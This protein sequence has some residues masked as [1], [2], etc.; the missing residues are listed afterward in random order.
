MLRKNQIEAL[1]ISNNNDFKSGVHFHATGTGKSWIG[2]QLILNYHNKYPNRNIIWIC[3][4]KSILIEQFNIN[5]L[6]EKGYYNIFT[7]F[8]VLNFSENKAKNWID[9]INSAKFWNKPLFVIINRAFLVSQEKYK[10]I[11]LPFS[12]LIHDECHSISNKT[13]QK[14][15]KWILKSTPNISCIGLSATP[16]ISIHPYKNILSKYSIYNSFCDN[17]IL[18]CKICWITS[19]SVLTYNNLFILFINLIKGLPYKKII[20]WCGMIDLCETLIK[21]I[22]KINY[23]SDFQ[24]FIDTSKSDTVNYYNKFKSIDEKAILFCACKHRE[25]SDIPNLDC[26]IFMDKVENRNPKTFVQCVG[27]VLR[28]D[29]LN[30][31]KYGLIIDVKA[32]NSMKLCNRMNEFLQLEPNIF[33]WKFTNI[34]ITQ[35]SKKYTINSMLL[36]KNNNQHS[37]QVNKF[38][39]IK[40]DNNLEKY[41]I[42]EIPEDDRYKI[43]YEKELSILKNKNLISYLLLAKDILDLSKNYP[44]VTRGSCG[45]SLI[46]YLLGISHVDP[47]QYNIHFE[48]FLNEYR[49]TLPD[50][51]F[52][53]PHNVRDEIFLKIEMKWPGKIARISNHIYYHPK[54]ALREAIRKNGY[55]K[56]IGKY[57][58]NKFIKSLP[59]IKQLKIQIDSKKL[60]NKFRCYSLHCG[61]IVFFPDGVPENLKLTEKKNNTLGQIIYNKKDISSCKKF[62]ID[63]LSS[64]ALSQIYTIYREPIQFE[65]DNY[66]QKIVDLL[67]SGD[68]IGLT[69]AESPLIRKAFIKIKPKNIEQIGICL[70][71]I[72][73]AAKEARLSEDNDFKDKFIFDDDGIEILSQ[74]LECEFD[75][76][77]KYRRGFSKKDKTILKEINDKLDLKLKKKYK[78]NYKKYKKNI[79]TKLN[80]LRK[81]SFCKSHSYSYGQLIWQLAYLKVYKPQK[82]WNATLLNCRSSYKKW[83]HYHEALQ[84]GIKYYNEYSKKNDIS[85]YS[86]NRKKKITLL[87]LNQQLKEYGYWDMEKHSDFYPNCYLIKNDN[88]FKIRGIIASSRMLSKHLSLFN[89]EKHDRLVLFIGIDTRQY[90]EIILELDKKEF[91]PKFI[92]IQC[93]ECELIDGECNIFISRKYKFF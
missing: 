41:F 7:Y 51:D 6:K 65:I 32:K 49:N 54:S 76:A 12:L 42:R 43:R 86:E 92:G 15:Y 36:V 14:F 52:D 89:K 24:L 57:E 33:P 48:R 88:K 47:I 75:L 37:K 22:K 29:K 69:L 84:F 21:I 20:I 80:N 5:I 13:T 53:F 8:Q 66:D 3:E 30:K 46:C 16:N 23:Y 70:A 19:Q 81:Y 63:I 9:G 25:G 35:N 85:I 10:K 55:H 50:I 64:R 73:P 93:N 56:F 82:F 38:D 77:D 44:H 59:K 91:I 17:I 62:K 90:C 1:E 11:K 39:L 72:R 18:P 58:I 28:K 67:S 31:K 2:L 87:S 40:K 78:Q 45:S 60:E 26:V 74:I 71:I 34:N 4:Q 68:N 61:G 27:R 79:I 83:V